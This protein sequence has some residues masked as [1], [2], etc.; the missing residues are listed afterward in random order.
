MAFLT[1]DGVYCYKVMS[2]GLKNAGATFTRMVSKIF[3][4]LLGKSVE[5]YVDDLLVKSKEAPENSRDL[6][7]C[8]QLMERYKLRLN[9][10]K[11]AFAVRGGK[12][13]GYMVTQR[14]IEPNP[15]KIKAILDMQPPTNLLEIQKLTG[16][17]AALSR[18]LSKS[19]KRSLPFFEVIK[20]R[21]GFEWTPECQASFEE[22]KKYLLSPPLLAKPKE[23]ETLYLY[24]AVSEQAVSSVLVRE[25]EKL[26]HPIYYISKLLRGAESRY[27]PL[28][29]MVYSLITTVRKLFPY[30]Q[31]H[32]VE[33]L[34]DQPLAGILRS[35]TSS[36]RMVKWAMELTQYGI[37]YKPRPSIK[38]Q[39]LADF[40]VEC[41]A[42]DQR[43]RA[44]DFSQNTW[45][46]M[47]AD[48]AASTKHCGGG[49]ML[50]SPEGFKVYYALDYQFKASNNEAE[51]EA[52]IGGI[53][54]AT[55]LGAH[56]LRIR[57]DSRLV[58]GQIKG[59]FE[60]RGEN[61][62]M[63]KDV[64]EGLLGKL[65]AY[66]I[67]HVPRTENMKA[68][69]LSK[70]SLGGTPGHLAHIWKREFIHAPS[71]ESLLIAMLAPAGIRSPDSWIGDLTRYITSAELSSD[72][73]QAAKV[74]RRAPAYQL[75]DNQL[76]KRSFGRP[77]LKCLPPSEAKQIIE[78][79]HS[80]I[81]AAHQGANTLARKLLVQGYYWLSMT[82][83]CIQRIQSCHTCQKFAEKQNR[84]ATF[85]MPVTTAIPFAKWGVDLLGPLP[86][87]PGRHKF[88]IV[89]I[90]YFTK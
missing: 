5:A 55:A 63:Y 50:T 83:D 2:F 3:H 64:T 40:I 69:L 49:I 57:T 86:Q 43:G 51:Y 9:P 48:G 84:P 88:C 68:D 81:C 27:T 70:I 66:E 75:V 74:K 62:R 14:G 53:R 17:L 67:Q 16:R 7:A 10:K 78:E 15:E 79:A 85:Y 21:E 19:A 4:S 41:T 58:V 38:A 33:V 59:T 77:L 65:D 28:E 45:W 18:F 71:T 29:K 6:K 12:F 36:G 39:A 34:T 76:Y 26:Q 23:G 46:E 22:L 44:S 20:R 61:L 73:V 54:L 72:P 42:R 1:P 37:E 32:P 30:F 13:L 56:N 31:A 25:E 52:V 89:A 90:D 87:A 60:T 11:C 47:S 82:Q 35:P 8:F 24:M 80:G